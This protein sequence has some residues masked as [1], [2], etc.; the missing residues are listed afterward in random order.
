M[1]AIIARH[2]RLD[3]G[4]VITKCLVAA[5]MLG[6]GIW[7]GFRTPSSE[8]YAVAPE[9]PSPEPRP[10]PQRDGLPWHQ[11]P[12]G[13]ILRQAEADPPARLPA[14]R[15]PAPVFA[16]SPHQAA[17]LQEANWVSGAVGS[18]TA[19]QDVRS[20]LVWSA[21]RPAPFAFGDRLNPEAVKS[22][23]LLKAL[24]DDPVRGRLLMDWPTAARVCQALVPAGSWRLPSRDEAWTLVSHWPKHSFGSELGSIWT[25]SDPDFRWMRALGY[26]RMVSMPLYGY[27]DLGDEHAFDPRL[28]G[29]A[30][31]VLIPIAATSL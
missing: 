13:R 17:D 16:A 30:R 14:E 12:L 5:A 10:G 8:P 3:R 22:Y 24:Y 28:P 29:R 4:T 6:L 11:D 27:R 20:G 2:Q 9:T 26:K 1:V 18:V 15:A 23:S 25:S 19:F 7:A 31:C 21:S